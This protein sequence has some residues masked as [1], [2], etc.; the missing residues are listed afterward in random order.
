MLGIIREKKPL[1]H[2]ITNWV[3]ISECASITRSLGALPVMAHA[4]EE[5]EEMVS[6]SGALVLNIGTLTPVLINAMIKAGKQA[7]LRGIPVILDIVGVGAT[8]LRTDSTRRI[9]SEVK[10][11]VIKGNAGEVATLAGAQAEVRGVESISVEGRTEE[12]AVTLAV[13]ENC[14]VV[15]T[16]AVDLVTDGERMFMIGNGHPMMG[17]VVGTG[18]MAASVIGSFAA[19]EEDVTLAAA[20]AMVVYGIAGEMAA[21]DAKGPG[22]MKQNLFDAIM[23]VGKED[24]LNGAKIDAR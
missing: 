3:T 18:C 21:V 19:V 8:G 5:V 24:I 23:A 20:C 12:H 16:A 17:E 1:V 7:N 9:L 10:I 13:S 6:I 22:S 15:V 2:H 11:A 4:E 14:T